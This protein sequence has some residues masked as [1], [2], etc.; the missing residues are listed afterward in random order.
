MRI[1]K[2]PP[3]KYSETFEIQNYN[4]GTLANQWKSYQVMNELLKADEKSG[5]LGFIHVN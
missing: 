5:F 1:G 2:K 4:L 3:I